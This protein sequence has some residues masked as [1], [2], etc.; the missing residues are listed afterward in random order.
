MSLPSP[1]QTR[2]EELTI[3]TSTPSSR[4]KSCSSGE[5]AKTCAASL[6]YPIPFHPP[7]RTRTTRKGIAQISESTQSSSNIGSQA[8]EP[9]K[10]AYMFHTINHT[11]MHLHS[12]DHVPSLKVK[13][14]QAF[15]GLSPLPRRHTLIFRI[16][17]PSP[18][19]LM[20]TSADIYLIPS[21]APPFPTHPSY[22]PTLQFSLFGARPPASA[23]STCL[24]D[25]SL[26]I[27]RFRHVRTPPSRKLCCTEKSYRYQIA[28]SEIGN[29]AAGSGRD[30]EQDY[31]TQKL[32]HS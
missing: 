21:E 20:A 6:Q 19:P 25:A 27:I 14:G 10:L 30:Q 9:C 16:C 15:A 22:Q 18:C 7:S 12:A 26:H 24:L 5:F 23:V 8:C 28:N 11:S 13:Q 1:P 17:P 2:Y 29:L 3:E 31:R 32:F 4:P